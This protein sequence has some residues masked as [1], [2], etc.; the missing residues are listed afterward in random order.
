M[1]PYRT[2]LQ[3]CHDNCEEPSNLPEFEGYTRRQ[4][5]TKRKKHT[6]SLAGT[7]YYCTLQSSHS[8]RNL[9]LRFEHEGIVINFRRRSVQGSGSWCVPPKR[10][11]TYW[12]CIRSL[13]ATKLDSCLHG[14]RIP[15]R[16]R[17]V[18]PVNIKN[19]QLALLPTSIKGLPVED[20][21]R[22]T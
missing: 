16:T 5:T 1:V 11:H 8:Q 22:I 18:I 12:E 10:S 14:L 2:V 21:E 3:W 4:V 20:N 6:Q 9:P 17:A 13:R 19:F 7:E 15:S